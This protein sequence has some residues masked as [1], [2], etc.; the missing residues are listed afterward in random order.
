MTLAAR[1]FGY[2]PRGSYLSDKEANLY[3][4]LFDEV[5]DPLRVPADP[6]IRPMR[7]FDE[8]RQELCTFLQVPFDSTRLGV[9]RGGTRRAIAAIAVALGAAAAARRTGG[10]MVATA[11]AGALAAVLTSVASGAYAWAP[12]LRFHDLPRAPVEEG[13]DGPLDKCM[14]PLSSL[15][16]LPVNRSNKR[17]ILRDEE[18]FFRSIRLKPRF[19]EQV[20]AGR[21]WA[22]A[23]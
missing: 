15:F 12:Q 5:T 10:S 21:L 17:R 8:S 18:Q 6:L 2:Y 16:G 13:W 4:L 1:D 11:A 23:R 7:E 20:H 22:I 19:H 14:P 3:E 9:W